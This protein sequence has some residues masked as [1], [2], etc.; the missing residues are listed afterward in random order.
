MKR[1]LCYGIFAGVGMMVLILDS[2]TAIDGATQA[3]TLCLTT[4]IPSLFPFFVLANLLTDSFSGTQNFLLR[5]LGRLLGLPLGAEGIFITGLLGGYPTGAQAVARAWENGSISEYDARRMLSFCSNAGPAFLFGIL[6]SKFS[7]MHTVWLI[8]GIHILSAVLT[9]RI[10]YGTPERSYAWYSVAHTDLSD[11]LKRAVTSTSLICGWIILFRVLMSFCSRWFLWLL[12]QNVQVAVYGALELAGGC[13]SL[14]A[15][16]NEGLRF[17]LASAMVSFG[18]VCVAMQT[19]SVTGKLGT[20]TYWTG[21]LLQS[22][23]S[24]CVAYFTQLFLFLADQRFTL[25]RL[26]VIGGVLSLSL[27]IL[28]SR[29]QQKATSIPAIVGV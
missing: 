18:G 17:V 6:G 24:V 3:V 8:W 7:G 11:A 21:K 12:P 28:L 13:C 10:S 16:T 20:K 1:R 26:L 19:A 27:C 14:D 23:I 22:S 4:V 2:K 9:A 25:P 5:P 29:K 15:V